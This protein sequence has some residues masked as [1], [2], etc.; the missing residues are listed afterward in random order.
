MRYWYGVYLNMRIIIVIGSKG[1]WGGW[2]EFFWRIMIM[3][4][5]RFGG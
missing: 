2:W 4:I 5:G 3:K 1:N